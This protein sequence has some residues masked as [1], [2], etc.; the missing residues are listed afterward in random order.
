MSDPGPGAA[1]HDDRPPQ[2]KLS[3]L[4]TVA[5]VLALLST[6]SLLIVLLAAV[7]GRVLW[8]GFTLFPAAFFPV[9]FVLMC[10][11][12]ARTALRRRRGA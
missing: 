3:V 10:V 1:V 2:R 8:S 7:G 9:A 6:V 12:L 5:L 11:E 4:A